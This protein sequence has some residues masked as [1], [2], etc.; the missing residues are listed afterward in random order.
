[1]GPSSPHR[2]KILL[3]DDDALARETLA[4]ML[5]SQGHSVVQASGGR[6]ALSLLEA[7]ESVDLVLTDLR[8]PGM[9]GW[10]LVDVLKARWPQLPLGL[11]TA[12]PQAL[13]AQHDRVDL[14]IPKPVP[15]DVLR[16]AISH[17]RPRDRIE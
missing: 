10:Q 11:M 5:A 2:L 9:T 3:V 7:G 17:I 13:S 8:M 6:R 15:L 12:T 14:V 4:E 1:M 16:A